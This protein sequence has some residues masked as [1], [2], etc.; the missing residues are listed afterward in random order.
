MAN[1]SDYLYR[2]A[3]INKIPLN[4]T[5]ELSPVCNFTCKMCYVRKTPVQLLE[6]GKSLIQWEQWL[7]LA[8]QCRDEGMLYLLLTGGEPF[9]Y[10]NFKELYSELHKMGF[11]ISINTNGTLI[12]DNVIEWLKTVAPYRINITLYGTSRETYKKICGFEDGY[13]SAVKAILKLKEAGIKVVINAS[14]IPENQDDLEEIIKFGQTHDIPTRIA[15]YMFPP[16][17]RDAEDSD[18]RFTPKEAADVFIR[19]QKCYLH[20]SEYYKMIENLINK[21]GEPV[22]LENEEIWGSNM[23]YMRC[24]AGRST[25]WVSWEGR[26]T[27]CG[28][29]D[30][31]LVEHP[32]EKR[33]H[34]C[35]MNLTNTVCTTK[36]L[37]ECNQCEKKEICNPC[38]AMLHSEHGDVNRKAQYMCEM[39]DYIISKMESELQEV[40]DCEIK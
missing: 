16:V 25:F 24:R 18:S 27:A 21:L 29:L 13:D 8:S 1:I 39:T 32:F 17:R 5:F 38:V 26:M 30:F 20:G 12:D 6:E 34:E 15:T 14:M 37:K 9:L 23:E 28:M 2:K 7:N 36:V 19:K 3:S 31:P 22:N 33:F 10:P 40:N 35:W 4:G 11:L